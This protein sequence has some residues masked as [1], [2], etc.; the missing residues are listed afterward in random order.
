MSRILT[1]IERAYPALSSEHSPLLEDQ[2]SDSRLMAELGSHVVDLFAAGC[3]GDIEPAFSL[4]E[5]FVRAGSEEEKHAAIVGFLETVQN[6]ASHREFGAA[7]FERFLGPS[8]QTAWTDLNE[9]WKGKTSLAEVVASETG[10]N[11]RPRWWQFWRRRRVRSPKELL[12]AVENPEL[13]KILEQIT[14][15]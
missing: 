6:A 9:Q 15:E 3:P 11:L 4:A 13:R 8:S 10:A 5:E 1:E 2:R 14:R 7:A 12:D